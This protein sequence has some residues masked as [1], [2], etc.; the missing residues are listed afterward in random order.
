MDFLP[1]E[2]KTAANTGCI[3]EDVCKIGRVIVP[4]PTVGTKRQGILPPD[5]AE[6]RG[7][8]WC[9]ASFD[10]DAWW[11]IFRSDFLLLGAGAV[12]GNAFW[13]WN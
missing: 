1:D 4:H 8:A 6:K 5:E 7:N 10:N 13:P 12:A 11:Q 3:C 9:I 2:A